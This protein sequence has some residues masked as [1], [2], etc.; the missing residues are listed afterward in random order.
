MAG[1][2]ETYLWPGALPSQRR[3][4]IAQS[5]IV[6]VYPHRN[7]V[8]AELWDALLEKAI[9]YVD[10]LVYVGMFLTEKPDLLKALRDKG[11]NGARVRLLFGDRDAPAVIQ[12]SVDEGIGERTIA[13]KIDHALA[14]FSALAGA[15]GIEIRTHGTVLYNSIYRFDHEM[16]VNPHVYGRVASHAP[17]FHLRRLSAGDLFTTYA[18]SFSRCGR[19]PRTGR[20]MQERCRRRTTTTIQQRRRL[21]ASSLPCRRGPERQGRAAA[22]RA[23]RQRPVGATRRGPGHR[24]IRGPGGPAR[25][26]RG[27]RHRGGNHRAEWHLLRSPACHRLRRRRSASGVLALLPCKTAQRR[28]AF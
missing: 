20:D 21:T 2:S 22:D 14:F 27:N 23:D 1:E 28:T 19:E 18:D 16:I 15:P 6:Q 7:S 9:A 5:E 10:I 26:L 12:R 17:A 8:P 25:G 24:R 11:E 13:A 3:A 4:E